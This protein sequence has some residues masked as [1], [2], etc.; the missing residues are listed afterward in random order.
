MEN[1]R[2]LALKKKANDIL[3]NLSISTIIDDLKIVTFLQELKQREIEDN[4]EE[5]LEKTLNNIEIYLHIKNKKKIN[6]T[7]RF[8]KN[9]RKII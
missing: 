3:A 4:E 1:D 8:Y 5:I 2:K 7:I 9:I 6:T